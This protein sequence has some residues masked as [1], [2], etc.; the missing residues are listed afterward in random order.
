MN[1]NLNV[2]GKLHIVLKDENGNIKSD[3]IIPNTITELMDAH[4]ADQM[5]DQ[6]DSQIGWIA[7]GTGTGQTSSS[8]DLATYNAGTFLALSGTGVVQGTGAN[9]NDVIYS[10]FWGAGIGTASIT[11]TG[12]FLGSATARADMM[13]YND[14]LNVVKGANDTLK[15]DWTVTFGAS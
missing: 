15:I 9:D 7:L 1:E 11:E 4:I 6:G 10:G 14:S 2:K 13:T 8:S 3:I 12:I 5:S